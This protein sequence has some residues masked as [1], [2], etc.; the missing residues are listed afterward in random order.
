MKKVIL[1][2]SIIFCVTLSGRDNPFA[3]YEEETGK[4]YELNE[5]P[6]TVEEIQEAQYIQK[7][8]NQ[9]NSQS[10]PVTSAPK[11]NVQKAPEK[12]YTKKELE[13]IVQKA[14][15]QNEQKTKEIVKKELANVKKEP[16]QVIYVKPR[17]D[18]D[19]DKT[20]T[21][22]NPS[23]NSLK[24]K[25]ILPF[26]NIENSDNELIIR[27]EHKMFKKFSI[28]KENKLA[29]DYKAK[30]NFNTKKE[31]LSGSNFKNITVGN[32]QKGGYY[33]VAVELGS[34]VSKYSVDVNDKEIVIKLK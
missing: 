3:K 25:N 34:K 12:T 24:Q 21:A 31:I 5:T 20:S 11:A 6:K 13:A 16:E 30:V 27:S 2:I 28:D 10:E 15:K 8:Q 18:V 14:N 9:I 19:S 26:L 29:F 7:I 4:M 33:R 32:H 1:G 17:A 22:V 23:S